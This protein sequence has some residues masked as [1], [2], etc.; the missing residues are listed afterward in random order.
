MMWELVK[1]TFYIF[2]FLLLVLMIISVVLVSVQTIQEHLMK[3]EI[4]KITKAL[5]KSLK[6]KENTK[7]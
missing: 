5:K 7:K 2:L 4:Y 6:N 3:Q 1:N